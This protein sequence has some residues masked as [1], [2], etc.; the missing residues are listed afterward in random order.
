MEEKT[1]YLPTEHNDRI[2]AF[3][4]SPLGLLAA[5]LVLINTVTFLIFGVDKL[6]AKHPRFRQRVPEKNLLLLAVVGGSVGALLGMYL[7]RHKT[8]HRVFRVGVPVILETDAKSKCDKYVH[9]GM[10]LA[11]VRDIGEFGKL[12]DLIKYP[13]TEKRQPGLNRLRQPLDGW[14][15]SIHAEKTKPRITSLFV[16]AEKIHVK[17]DQYRRG[18]F[19]PCGSWQIRKREY[20]ITL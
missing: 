17:K 1:L 19:F 4:G 12:Y 16:G 5:W 15:I 14:R 18:R 20:S 3:I 13:N 2:V 8:L 7:F 11:G 6:L 9:L 10:K